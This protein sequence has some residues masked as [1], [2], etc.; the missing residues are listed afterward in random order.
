M[1]DTIIPLVVFALLCL[2]SLVAALRIFRDVFHPLCISSIFAFATIVGGA[3]ASLPV[4]LDPNQNII[5]FHSH[6]WIYCLGF[7]AFSFG[8]LFSGGRRARKSIQNTKFNAEYRRRLIAFSASMAAIS[9]LVYAL[10]LAAGGGFLEVYSQVKGRGDLGSGVQDLIMVCVPAAV[11]YTYSRR[12]EPFSAK[13]FL[14]LI[15]ILGPLLIGG[16]LSSRRGPTAMALGAIFFGFYMASG[17]RPSLASLIMAAA[18]GGFFVLFLV[19]YRSQIFIGSDIFSQLSFRDVFSAISEF[20]S[21]A[22]EGHEFIYSSIVISNV[23]AQQDY[24][25]G[26]RYML[27]NTIW[28][29]PSII[30]PNKYEFF[31]ARSLYFNGGTLGMEPSEFGRIVGAAPMLFADVYVEFGPFSFI[32]LFFLGTFLGRLWRNAVLSEGIYI[33]IYVSTLSVMIYLFAQTF[34][35][36][37]QRIIVM[38]LSSWLLWRLIVIRGVKFGSRH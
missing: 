11:A 8:C 30:F 17:R 1:S 33:I 12:G 28:L 35:A 26:L 7:L 24:W 4:I 14:I 18:V 27:A 34:T 29:V 5:P 36:F 3:L 22:D 2:S 19:A 9:W 32:F 6:I 16:I 21:E 23:Q 20:I 13:N 15:L 31:G 37:S 10:Q 25:W 38:S